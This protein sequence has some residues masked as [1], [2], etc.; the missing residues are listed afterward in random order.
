MLY[1]CIR[2]TC[3]NRRVS[4]SMCLAKTPHRGL[5]VC[6]SGYVV[7]GMWFRVFQ[8]A[9]YKNSSKGKVTLPLPFAQWQNYT[10]SEAAWNLAISTPFLRDARMAFCTRNVLSTCTSWP[11]IADCPWLPTSYPLPSAIFLLY[12]KMEEEHGLARHAM[13]IYDRACKAVA[14]DDQFEVTSGCRL[15]FL[16]KLITD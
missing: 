6:G 14:I 1:L 4:L 3:T 12:A 10:Q 8:V 7:Q 2:I 13:A 5:P 15:H 11:P 16:N 9:H